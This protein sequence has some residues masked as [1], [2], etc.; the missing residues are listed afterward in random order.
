MTPSTR[1]FANAARQ[2]SMI[3]VIFAIG[4]ADG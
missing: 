1:G 4:D 3:D 2:E